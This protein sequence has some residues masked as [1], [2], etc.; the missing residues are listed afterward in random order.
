MVTNDMPKRL[1]VTRFYAILAAMILVLLLLLA[2]PVA[3]AEPDHTR[4]G[5]DEGQVVPARQVFRDDLTVE[6]G[7][8]IDD[9]VFVYSGNVTVEEGGQITGDLVVFSGNVEIKES[10][11]VEGDLTAYSG[12]VIIAGTI[13]GDLASM[14]GNVD[15]A[16]SAHVNGDISVVSGQL[17]RDEGATVEGNVIQG[18]SFRFP[19]VPSPGEPAGPAGLS[20]EPPRPS[21]FDSVFGFFARLVVAILITALTML[22]VGGL[23]YLRPQLIADTRARLK[24]QL[25]LSVVIGGVANLTLL[26]LAGMLAITI[27]LLPLALVPMLVLLAVNVVGWAVASQI[28]GERIASAVNQ[29]VQPALTILVGALVLTGI[30]ALLWAFGGC[31]RFIAFLLVFAISSLGTGAA[32]LPWINRRR[33]SGGVDG[34]GGGDVPPVSPSGP[35]GP[36]RSGVA[37]VDTD[38]A[39]PIDYVTA[40]EVNLAGEEKPRSTSV[41]TFSSQ[42]PSSSPTSDLSDTDVAEPIDYLTAEEIN[43]A[44]EQDPSAKTTSGRKSGRKSAKPDMVETDAAAP[45]DYV[46]AEEVILAE[47]QA[48][49]AATSEAKS[50]GSEPDSDSDLTSLV[51]NAVEEDVAQPIDYVTAQEVITTEAV[52]EGDDFLRIKGVGPTFARRL[53]EAGYATFAQLGAASPEAVAEAIGWPENR[54]RRAE[55]IEQAQMLA[56]QS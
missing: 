27:C 35:T 53:K 14:S 16:S 25:A 26:F 39:A 56:R 52:T 12:N 54:V 19:G 38:V 17:A 23:Y 44:G 34:G 1:R 36:A 8:V 5:V 21:F 24:D 43:M 11:E 28:V 41:Q 55:I 49:P 50:G 48:P 10:S 31:F 22:L 7:Q 20:F 33:G 47:E 46:T 9:D 51:A 2:G 4:L 13:G 37:P 18:P 40:E 30:C 45:I 32:L 3:A 42:T 6:A 15:L 29:E